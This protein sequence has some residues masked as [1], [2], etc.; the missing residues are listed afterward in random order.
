MTAAAQQRRQDLTEIPTKF[1]DQWLTPGPGPLEELAEGIADEV[2]RTMKTRTRRDAASRRRFIVGNYVANLAHLRLWPGVDSQ[3]RLAISTAHLKPTRYDREDYP[4][5]LKGKVMEAMEEVGVLRT[6]D[7]VFKR[8][9]TAVE[10]TEGFKFKLQ[11]IGIRPAHIS[12]DPGGETIWLAARTGVR[13]RFGGPT[14][15]R[16]IPYED[17]SESNRFREEMARINATLSTSVLTFG[18][19]AVPPFLLRRN[20]LLRSLQDPV[21]FNL[22]G[23]LGGGFWMSLSA[24][25]RHKLAIRG[26]PVADLDYSAMFAHLAYARC[27]EPMPNVDPYQIPGLED[28]RDGAK[29]ALISLLSRSSDMQL[30]SPKL[31]AALPEGWTAKKLVEAATRHHPRIAHLFGTDVGLDL[32]F[33]ESQLLVRLLLDLGEEDIPAL[34]MHDGVMVAA[35]DVERARW[36][37]QRAALD[38]I[39]VALPIKEKAI[40]QPT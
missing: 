37:M 25:Q 3:A 12:R 34:P 40:L 20:F 7:Y 30:L 18:G 11:S 14:P 9:Q 36:K 29:L 10:P 33:T 6:H 15:K 31:K 24:K 1:F 21:E 27:G 22:N 28:H 39:G 5:G 16:T 32:M 35:Q 38:A 13:S 26:E 19:E 17:T 23:R 2:E 4:Y 8:K